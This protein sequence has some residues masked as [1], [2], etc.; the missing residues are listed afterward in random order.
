MLWRHFGK[1]LL[2]RI[3]S[4]STNKAQCDVKKIRIVI[5]KLPPYCESIETVYGLLD[6]AEHSKGVLELHNLRGGSNILRIFQNNFGNFKNY[7]FRFHH[8][9]ETKYPPMKCSYCFLTQLKALRGKVFLDQR[10][11]P[12]VF[13]LTFRYNMY[14]PNKTITVTSATFLKFRSWQ[15]DCLTKIK[16]IW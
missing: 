1:G 14:L 10:K 12:R 6:Y 16:W 9:S 5:T 15:D 11:F 13:L 4:I 2:L 3:F 8:Q 7:N